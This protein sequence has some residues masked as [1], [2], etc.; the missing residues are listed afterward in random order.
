MRESGGTGFRFAGMPGLN[1][2]AGIYG[3]F[4][5]VGEGC[6]AFGGAQEGSRRNARHLRRP[7][8]TNSLDPV[9]GAR[10]MAA[11]GFGT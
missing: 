4:N 1:V 6:S 11:A 8:A 9:P 7:L 10:L 5:A 3:P 2:V